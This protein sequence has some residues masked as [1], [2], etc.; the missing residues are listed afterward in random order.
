MLPCNRPGSKPRAVIASF[1]T[2]GESL[3]LCLFYFPP[4]I[5][6]ESKWF[7]PQRAVCRLNELMPR[8]RAAPCQGSVTVMFI[9][10]A[11]LQEV[12]KQELFPFWS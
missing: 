12:T 6:W 1:G 2:L 3:N 11:Q 7:Q 4:S 8:K 10:I 9:F 5:K